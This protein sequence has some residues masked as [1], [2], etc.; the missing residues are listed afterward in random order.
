MFLSS[1]YG[2]SVMVYTNIYTYFLSDIMPLELLFT[3]L[4][5]WI[6]YRHRVNKKTS[7]ARTKKYLKVITVV[8]FL[9]LL[10]F[11]FMT[12]MAPTADQRDVY[13]GA[14]ELLQGNYSK[15]MP[16]GIFYIYPFQSGIV[17]LYCPFILLFGVEKAYLAIAVWN[18]FC[19][20]GTIRGLTALTKSWFGISTARLV[21]LLLLGFFPMWGYCT[22]VYGT[23]PGL[24]FAVTAFWFCRR[25]E[26]RRTWGSLAGAALCIG[27]AII[28]KSNY[29]I[30]LIALCSLFLFQIIF[31]KNLRAFL[32]LF[33]VL[34]VGLFVTKG[35][36]GIM[37]EITGQRTDQ[38]MPAVAWIAMGLQE[39]ST[40]PGWYNGYG[41]TLYA[42]NNNQPEKVKEIAIKNIR[43]SLENFK[44]NKEYTVEFF[45]KKIASIW[46]DPAFEGFTIVNT[47]DYEQSLSY[48]MKDILYD[49]GIE[50]VLLLFYYNAM[51]S[52]IWAG[53]IIFLLLHRKKM[54]I[55]YMGLAITFLGGFLFHL[56]WEAKCQYTVVYYV[57]LF[58]YA[59]AGYHGLL[60]KM[61]AAGGIRFSV[62]RQRGS[63]RL[64][65]ILLLCIFLLA[66]IPSQTLQS[67]I[68][69]GGQEKEYI[70]YCL[71]ETQWKSSDYVRYGDND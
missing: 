64:A 57:L 40:A 16:S 4:F 38:G 18:A 22:F 45:G 71:H 7:E 20:Y 66:L 10:G 54:K 55:W 1:L 25:F 63:V 67:T 39:A 36:P 42:E 17:L 68:K 35:I 8:W 62:L 3:G 70:W 52:V 33:L 31:R 51:Q 34:F 14:A 13:M 46:N 65:E 48:W 32:G 26:K 61:V 50:N 29:I 43:E 11:I 6:L 49:G 15:W 59:A 41:L 28:W 21:Y 69:L 12:Q 27:T 24:F 37:T 53:M 2:T 9:L 5:V 44:D 19:W 23:L 58:P 30:F 60:E 56:F 47:K